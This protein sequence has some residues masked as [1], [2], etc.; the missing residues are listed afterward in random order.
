MKKTVLITGAARGI[1]ASCAKLFA[2]KGYRVAIN[3]FKS[4][5]KAEALLEKINQM[6]GSSETFYADISNYDDVKKMHEEV[7]NKLGAPDVLINNAGIS[8]Q[9]LFTDITLKEWDDMFDVNAKGVFIC[10]KEFLPAMIRKKQGR[11]INISSI[12]GVLGGSCEVHYSASKAA[13]IGLSKALA[14][15]VAPSNITVNCI[16]PGVISTDMMKIHSQ[17]TIKLLEKEIACQKLGR[18][19]DVA[20]AALFLASD[21]ASYITGQVLNV[22]GGF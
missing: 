16:A 19:E 13:I 20:N 22:D 11:I 3:Y 15:E 6:G 8:Q 4:K 5:L 1:G 9:K 7:E 10:C 2:K 12:W 14:K 18:P 17:E 21:E